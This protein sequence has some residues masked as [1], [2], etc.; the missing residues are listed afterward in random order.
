MELL[1]EHI[2][3]LINID[4]V[5]TQQVLNFIDYF[6]DADTYTFNEAEL[7]EQ[8]YTPIRRIER[9]PRGTSADADAPVA[10]V[11]DPAATTK[12]KAALAALKAR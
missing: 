1:K 6:A 11:D 5:S 12:L 9:T 10:A 8:P 4:P 3:E 7:L 2:D